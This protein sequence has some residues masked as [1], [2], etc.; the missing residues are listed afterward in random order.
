MVQAIKGLLMTFSEESIKQ[1]ALH[2][3]LKY[4]FIIEDID[5]RNVFIDPAQKDFVCSEIDRILSESMY[6]RIQN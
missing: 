6:Q 2:L 5:G 4:N 1:I 3:D